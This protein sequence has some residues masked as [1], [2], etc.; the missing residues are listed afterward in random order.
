MNVLA[1]LVKKTQ[2]K[3]LALLVKSLALLKLFVLV[4]AA[5]AAAADGAAGGACS[6][7]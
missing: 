1:A 6:S 2:G 7:D 4:P 5:A 3:K